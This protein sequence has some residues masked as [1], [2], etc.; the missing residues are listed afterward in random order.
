MIK[1]FFLNL[2]LNKKLILMMLVMTAVLLVTLITIYWQS[3]KN[4]LA[5]LESQTAELAQAVQVG[6]EEVTGGASS[7]TRLEKYLSSLKTKGIKEIS[8]I[9]NADEIIASTNPTKVGTPVSQRKKELIIKAELGEPAVDQEGKAY[10]VIIP[11]IAGQAHYGYIH[12][13]INVENLQE[14]MRRNTTKRIIAAL[15]VFAIGILLSTFLSMWYTDPIHNVV[16]A[17]R[18]V[19]AG[20][21]NQNL[22][23]DRKDEIGDLTRSFNFMVQRLREQ[24]RLEERLREAEHLSAMGQLSRGIAHEIRNPLN[25]ISLSIDHIRTKYR[26]ADGSGLEGFEKLVESMKQEIHRLDRLVRDF[27]DYGKPLKLDRQP[28]RTQE[29][30][31][32]VVEI[33]KAK[34]ASDRIRI[35]ERY[36]A[37]PELRLDAEL[38]KSCIFNVVTNA[39]QA[40]PEGGTLT[41]HSGERDGRFVLRIAD[42]GTGM[43]E[44]HMARIFEPFFT[45]KGEGLGLGL[46]MTKRVI[47]EH[48]GRIEF[49]SV[50]GRGSEVT[51]S[52]PLA[53]ADGTRQPDVSQG[54]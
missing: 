25:F 48:G 1:T 45:T 8:I 51:I 3:E 24:R 7:E 43:S 40:M 22:P 21:L 17:A 49:T 37:V 34:A 32:D 35:D 5:Q 12:L 53:G 47:E 33:V 13:Q 11:V 42:T 9:S 39:F 18:R 28:C 20:D 30:L 31:A 23:V 50:E 26:P 6:V 52:L 44:E 38:M 46:A 36:D 10:N 41:L 27:L 2:S 19:A 29:L 15:S 14:T 54:A 16:A 4:L